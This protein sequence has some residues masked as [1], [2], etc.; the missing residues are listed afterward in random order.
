M[1]EP[2]QDLF[3][4]GEISIYRVIGDPVGVWPEKSGGIIQL[5]D[6]HCT[7]GADVAATSDT[8]VERAIAAFGAPSMAYRTFRPA[9]PPPDAPAGSEGTAAAF[10]LLLAAL[11]GTAGIPGPLPASSPSM[12]KSGTGATPPAQSAEILPL[13]VAATREPAS[14]ISGSAWRGADPAGRHPNQRSAAPRSPSC[15]A[16]CALN[17]PGRSSQHSRDL[18]Y[19]RICSVAFE[20]WADL[21]TRPQEPSLPARQDP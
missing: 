14:P 16:C 11:P 5:A 12:V 15:S 1:T 20:K 10:P 4:F 21:I 2:R 13:P 17:R 3:A 18:D 9:S 6:H 7:K 19:C 8:D